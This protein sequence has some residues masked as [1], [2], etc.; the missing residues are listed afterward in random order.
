MDGE[1]VRLANSRRSPVG[2]RCQNRTPEETT[3]QAVL[4]ALV[5]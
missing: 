3:E 1:W 5:R 2:Q 4:G